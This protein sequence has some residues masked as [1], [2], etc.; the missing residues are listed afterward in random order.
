MLEVEDRVEGQVVDQVDGLAFD[1]EVGLEVGQVV[2]QEEDLE[3]GQ[4]V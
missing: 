4:G 1:L 2:C 3:V